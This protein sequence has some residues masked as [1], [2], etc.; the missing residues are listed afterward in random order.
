MGEE[1]KNNDQEIIDDT[2]NLVKKIIH[3]VGDWIVGDAKKKLE[4]ICSDKN[5][6]VHYEPKKKVGE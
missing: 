6:R 1:V 2:I 4:K 5:V 3:R